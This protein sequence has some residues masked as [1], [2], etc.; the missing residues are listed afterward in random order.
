MLRGGRGRREREVSCRLGLAWLLV[1]AF[2]VGREG[3]EDDGVLKHKGWAR[4]DPREPHGES[5]PC[6]CL[7]RLGDRRL[8]ER[9]GAAGQQGR[10]L[11][12]GPR[13]TGRDAA[14]STS[15]SA[16][17]NRLAVLRMC[18]RNPRPDVRRGGRAD[19]PRTHHRS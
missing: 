16:I 7:H 10:D 17:M 8:D 4:I 14:A 11:N 12:G 19:R 15:E 9:V 18:L 5:A 13:A 2:H 6:R 3:L 1:V